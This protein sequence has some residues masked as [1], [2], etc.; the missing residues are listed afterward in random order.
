M[1]TKISLNTANH[2][3]TTSNT[4]TKMHTNVTGY[5]TAKNSLNTANNSQTDF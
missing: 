3:Q 1:T 5:T 2:N 4:L